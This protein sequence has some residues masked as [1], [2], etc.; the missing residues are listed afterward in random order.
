MA[1]LLAAAALM[2]WGPTGHHE[3]RLHALQDE[4]TALHAAMAAEER[5]T[6]TLS[7]PWVILG[8]GQAAPAVD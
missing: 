6:Q 1:C 3:A 2:L 5:L 4:V 7:L 8:T